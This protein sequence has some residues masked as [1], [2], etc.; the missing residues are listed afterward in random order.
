MCSTLH[1]S[2]LKR[3]CHF[4]LQ[5]S[6][7]LRYD[8]RTSLSMCVAVHFGV[9]CEHVGRGCNVFWHVVYVADEQHFFNIVLNILYRGL[10]IYFFNLL[11]HAC[12]GTTIFNFECCTVTEEGEVRRRNIGACLPFEK[13]L[14]PNVTA[15]AHVVHAR[16][17]HREMTYVEV[18][19]G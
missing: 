11:P 9:I 6:W 5:S 1:L 2:A 16:R 19:Q 13:L 10:Y 7:R 12:P 15:A 3:S 8:C 4:L 17:D 18:V 14:L